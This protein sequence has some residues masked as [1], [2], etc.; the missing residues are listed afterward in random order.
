MG[1]SF[2]LA[3]VYQVEAVCRTPL[4]T[5]G[6]ERDPEQVLRDRDGTA[7][8]QGSSLAGALRDYLKATEGQALAACLLGSPEQ[9]GHLMVSDAVFDREA[10]QYTRPRLHID[11]ASA[12]GVKGGKF[13]MAHMGQ[14]AK[15]HFSLVW[16][17]RP[18]ERDR[19]LAA[20]EGLLSALDAGAI[21]LGAQKSNGFGQISLA[22]KRRL[23]DLTDGE[24]RRAWLADAWDGEPLAL[25][26]RRRNGG[27]VFTVTGRADNILIKTVPVLDEKDGKQYTPN[28][29]EDGQAL[30]PG[31]SVKGAVRARAEYIARLMGL[32]RAFTDQYFGRDAQE[33]GSGLPGQ[34]RFE[35]AL[36]SHSRK[37]VSRIRIDRFTGGVQRAGLF[38]EEPVSTELELRIAAPEA[39]ALCGLLV[40]ALRDLGLGLYNLGSG[41]AIGRGQVAVREIRAAAPDGQRAALRFDRQRGI[42]TDDPSGLL[43]SW[44]NALEE[45]RHEY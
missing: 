35:D 43:E 14:G 42:V 31:S 7:F 1:T 12:T 36:L 10:D 38:T 39:S 29:S 24:D 25:V 13:D 23:F 4:R 20:V 37:K 26:P 18:E 21:R 40:Y 45:A 22:A 6:A 2:T 32:D 5:G 17:G 44:A 16:L 27:V 34:V 3:A 15:L 9:T 19:E 30:L 28:L 11:P 8:L 33:G 41:W